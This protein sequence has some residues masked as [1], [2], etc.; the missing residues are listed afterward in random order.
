MRFLLV[1]MALAA[2]AV[3]GGCGEDSAASQQKMQAWVGKDFST[4]EVQTLDGLPQPLKDAAMDGKPVVL[5]VWATWCSPCL[6]EMPTLAELGKQG[7]FTVVAIA[8]DA[9]AQAVKEFL[10]KQT[11]GPGVQIW[12]DPQGKVTR[13]QMGAHTIPVTFILDKNLKVR[14][15][16]A[17][18][19]N[20]NHPKMVAKIRE[21]VTRNP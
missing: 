20:W 14:A 19:R 12:F 11:W 9:K 13:E 15:V 10:K 6:A 2:G 16:E 18:E 8:T 21:A 4:L 7:E 3:L 1:L 5:N 17:G